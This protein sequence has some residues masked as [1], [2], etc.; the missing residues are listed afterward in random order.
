MCYGHP[1]Y[2]L[3]TVLKEDTVASV[4]VELC[5]GEA[6]HVIPKGALSALPPFSLHTLRVKLEFYSTF[7]LRMHA[8]VD[9]EEGST[10]TIRLYKS[11]CTCMLY[12]VWDYA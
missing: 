7:I 10:Y 4:G 11:T 9:N 5:D 12:N 8:E 1:H 3:Y 2:Y 6:L